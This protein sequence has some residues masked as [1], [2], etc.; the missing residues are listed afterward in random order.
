M[1][2]K[3]CERRS[4]RLQAK[5]E[6]LHGLQENCSPEIPIG[7]QTEV[8]AEGRWTA[9]HFDPRSSKYRSDRGNAE[10]VKYVMVPPARA[11]RR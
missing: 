5:L 9:H 1:L 3:Q 4:L 6:V 2:A 8:R 7:R 10:V 11:A